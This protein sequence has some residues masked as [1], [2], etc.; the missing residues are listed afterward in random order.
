MEQDFNA[1]VP[2]TWVRVER[3]CKLT[4]EPLSTV[5]ERASNGA[6]EAG[7]HFKKLSQRTIVVNLREINNWFDNLPPVASIVAHFV[8]QNPNA[9]VSL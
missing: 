8:K 6:W 1:A 4:G 3:Y 7:L 2:L 5:R 9:K